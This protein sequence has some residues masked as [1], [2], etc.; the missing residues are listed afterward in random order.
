MLTFIRLFSKIDLTFRLF[1]QLLKGQKGLGLVF[2]QNYKK[3]KL[4]IYL[5]YMKP[6]KVIID[7]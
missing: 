6:V 2:L 7:L 1:Q 4:R 3:N 5:L